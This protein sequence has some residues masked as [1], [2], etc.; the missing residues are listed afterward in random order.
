MQY[1]NMPLHNTNQFLW[2]CGT[3]DA[4]KKWVLMCVLVCKQRLC[5]K[6]EHKNKVHNDKTPCLQPGDGLQFT[7][8]ALFLPNIVKIQQLQVMN[9]FL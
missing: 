2:K 5:Y 9:N 3:Q 8:E 4:S 6:S 1:N 7:F